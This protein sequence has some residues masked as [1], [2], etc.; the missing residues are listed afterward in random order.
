MEEAADEAVIVKITPKQ[1]SY[2][3]TLDSERTPDELVPELAVVPGG[4]RKEEELDSETS[5]FGDKS[6]IEPEGEES[7]FPDES[8]APGCQVSIDYTEEP[9]E[10]TEDVKKQV[11]T[12]PRPAKLKGNQDQGLLEL[13]G[14]DEESDK[15]ITVTLRIEGKYCPAPFNMLVEKITEGRTGNKKRKNEVEVDERGQSLAV[16]ESENVGPVVVEVDVSESVIGKLGLAY[17]RGEMK[18]RMG[19]FLESWE[20]SD[21]EKEDQDDGK[22][23]GATFSFS[24]D[25]WD[26]SSSRDK[27]EEVDEET[28]E[29]I[30][31]QETNDEETDKQPKK[32]KT[33]GIKPDDIKNE[34]INKIQW[35]VDYSR[36]EEVIA[37]LASSRTIFV[38]GNECPWR[39]HQKLADAEKKEFGL[40]SAPGSLGYFYI[41]EGKSSHTRTR[42]APTSDSKQLLVKELRQLLQV[43]ETA[44]KTAGM[45][46]SGSSS[47][48]S[49]LLHNVEL[50]PFRK[51]RE[52]VDF[53]NWKDDTEQLKKL[54][55]QR[56]QLERSS[57]QLNHEEDSVRFVTPSSLQF[58]LRR[59]REREMQTFTGISKSNQGTEINIERMNKR[60]PY[61]TACFD[62]LPERGPY[63]TACHHRNHGIM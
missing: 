27:Y 9:P 52:F 10:E 38:S 50:M 4:A 53:G 30:D 41:Q 14:G 18:A 61:D 47:T 15:K 62:C 63:N 56:L 26:W 3:L 36:C 17:R 20:Q 23:D 43:G 5:E 11:Q 2:R 22:S 40:Q 1:W 8:T 51:L 6:Q 16:E 33:L 25:E 7:D 42:W 37:S 13:A 44:S 48:M 24:S 49:L 54:I 35:N 45:N 58:T 19:S 57:I 39:V 32:K 29:E 59:I 12:L 31:K 60:G 28:N 55:K 21:G 46:P 34:T